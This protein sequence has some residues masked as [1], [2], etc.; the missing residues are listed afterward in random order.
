MLI[1]FRLLWHTKLQI[2]VDSKSY[3]YLLTAIFVPLPLHKPV[4]TIVTCGWKSGKGTKNCSWQEPSQCTYR[5]YVDDATLLGDD[6]I[7]ISADGGGV[8]LWMW[9][10][11][12]GSTLSLTSCL[13]FNALC[14]DVGFDDVMDDVITDCCAGS[15][16]LLCF[17]WK[18]SN[19][20]SKDGR[21]VCVCFGVL[22]GVLISTLKFSNSDRES[23]PIS[24]LFV[25]TLDLD[26]NLVSILVSALIL[27]SWFKVLLKLELNSSDSVRI[28]PVVFLLASFQL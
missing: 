13:I 25:K 2:L 23:V 24:A 17:E 5:R 26:S 28:F 20:C 27:V 4:F 9:D 6:E 16:G 14:G 22:I 3:R 15:V 8:L 10:P 19:L 7:V 1:T 12:C 11:V 18:F 21:H